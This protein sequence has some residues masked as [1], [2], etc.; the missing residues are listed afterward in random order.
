VLALTSGTRLYGI[1]LTTFTAIAIAS[2]GIGFVIFSGITG[3]M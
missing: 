2:G 1:S 3:G